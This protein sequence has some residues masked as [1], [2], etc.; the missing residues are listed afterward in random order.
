M[1]MEIIH[2]SESTIMAWAEKVNSAIE[3]LKKEE[4]RS[5]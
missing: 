5:V 4:K 3:K 2:R 1:E